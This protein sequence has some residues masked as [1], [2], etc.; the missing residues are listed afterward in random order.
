MPAQQRFFASGFQKQGGHGESIS[1]TKMNEVRKKK[2]VP[3]VYGTQIHF[4]NHH[5]DDPDLLTRFL[6]HAEGVVN[7]SGFMGGSDRG[8]QPRQPLRYRR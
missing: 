4:V 6:D 5:L 3:D 2:R 8:P 1:L 7:L